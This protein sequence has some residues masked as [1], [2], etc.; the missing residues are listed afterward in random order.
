MGNQQEAL[1]IEVLP[2]V[3]P[4]GIYGFVD[5]KSVAQTGLGID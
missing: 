5:G 3:K 4:D 2:E 1:Q